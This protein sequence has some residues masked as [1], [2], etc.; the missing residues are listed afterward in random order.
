MPY[1]TLRKIA[2]LRNIDSNMSKG[3]TIYSLIRSE[4]VINEKKVHN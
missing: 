4:P 3:D 1:K 2:K